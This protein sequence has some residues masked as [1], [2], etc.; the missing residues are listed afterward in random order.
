MKATSFAVAHDRDRH[1][2]GRARVTDTAVTAR[3]SDRGVANSPDDFLRSRFDI[4]VNAGGLFATAV[5]VIHALPF[6]P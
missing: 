6:L 3:C 1:D 5:S 2:Q 4:A